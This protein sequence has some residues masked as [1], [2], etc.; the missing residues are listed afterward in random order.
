MGFLEIFFAHAGAQQ[1]AITQRQRVFLTLQVLEFRWGAGVG[2]F[3]DLSQRKAHLV[4]F[5]DSQNL[6]MDCG[7]LRLV[8]Q[9]K[10]Q[11]GCVVGIVESVAG[12]KDAP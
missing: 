12:R 4:F 3:G 2:P 6:L 7:G 5:E 11:E 10:P 1:V 9:R 8:C